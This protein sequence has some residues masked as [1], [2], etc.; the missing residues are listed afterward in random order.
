MTIDIKDFYLCTPLKRYEYLRLKLDDI[1]QDVIEHYGLAD[2]AVDGY[3]YVEIRGGMYGLPQAGILAQEL[4]EKRLEKHGYSQSQFTPGFWSHKTRPIQ[5]S[6][7]VDDF[8]VKYVGKQHVDHLI[9]VLKEHYQITEDWRGSKYLGLD[10]DWDYE[11]REVHLSMLDYVRKALLRFQHKRPNRPQHQP[12][13]HVPVQYGQKIQYTEPEDDTAKLDNE[14]MK[15]IMQVTGVFLYYARAVDGLMLPALSAI[16]TEQASPTE[17]TM[18][19]TK[20]FLDYAATHPDAVLTYRASDMVLAIHSNASFLNEKRSRSRM[21]GH[22]F[23]SSNT[24]IPANNGAVLNLSNIIKAVMS[25]AAESELGGLFLNAKHAVPQRKLL[26]EMGHPQPPTPIQTDNSTAYGVVN[27]KIQPKAT[28]SMDMRF[29]WLRD[30]EAQ[31][32]FRI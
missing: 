28:K 18:A 26:E 8:G 22:H 6:L 7:V 23:L 3:V 19:R 13:P 12:Y 5:F 17:T 2:K 14:G 16:A 30:R 24:P 1:P 27:H 21:G 20:Q 9:G 32:Q 4:L 25:S 11:K 15:Y 31:K 10:L 29:H